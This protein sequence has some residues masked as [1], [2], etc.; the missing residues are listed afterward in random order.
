VVIKNLEDQLNKLQAKLDSATTGKMESDQLLESSKAEVQQLRQDLQ[1][2]VSNQ[3]S[4]SR[5]LA[6]E[7]AKLKTEKKAAEQSGSE[8]QTENERLKTQLEQVMIRDR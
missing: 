4:V 1:V 2:A 8:C 3:E 7:L 6:D 5:S